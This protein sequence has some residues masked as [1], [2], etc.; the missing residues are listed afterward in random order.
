MRGAFG[1]VSIL[2]CGL[3]VAYVWSSNTQS[4]SKVNKTVR[5][6]VQQMAG[7]NADGTRAIDSA[8][9]AAVESAGALKGIRVTSIDPTGALSSYWGLM[10]NDVVQRIGP[11]TVG[12]SSIAD[13]DTA[14][15]WVVEGMQ[16]KM[17]MTVDRGGQTLTLP[18]QR[19]TGTVPAAGPGAPAGAGGAMKSADD[20]VKQL[21]QP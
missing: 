11:F 3:I 1:L 16:R 12:D 4:I 14:R 19:S 5:P 13:L 2:V 10:T 20:L 18:A 9:F 15:E 17:E 8:K 7:Q 21:Q 6:Q